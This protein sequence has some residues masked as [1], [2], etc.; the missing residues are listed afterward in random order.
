[1]KNNKNLTMAD[2]LKA[3]RKLDNIVDKR[4]FWFVSRYI[5]RTYI[6]P[7]TQEE[8]DCIYYYVNGF[9]RKICMANI[10]LKDQ[11]VEGLKEAG[12]IPVE[13]T[14]AIANND[15][16]QDLLTRRNPSPLDLSKFR[17]NEDK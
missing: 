9:G 13:Y 6:N 12:M 8:E 2:L 14:A 10:D 4:V 7:K 11:I 5:P 17:Q 1:M 15:L 3:K 16:L